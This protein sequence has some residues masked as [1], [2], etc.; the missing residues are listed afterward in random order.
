MSTKLTRPQLSFQRGLLQFWR[1]R[2]Q[3]DVDDEVQRVIDDPEVTS[4]TMQALLTRDLRMF[5]YVGLNCVGIR[6][7][8][9]KLAEINSELSREP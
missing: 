8:D 6:H 4:P 7:L 3:H 2:I 9:A 5:A 1:D